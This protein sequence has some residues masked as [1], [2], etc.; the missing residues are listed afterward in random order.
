MALQAFGWSSVRPRWTNQMM[1][2]VSPGLWRVPLAPLDSMNAYLLDDVLVDSG[3]R[4]SAGRLLGALAGRAVRAH[5]VTHA[6]FDH[7]GASH[8]VC[9]RFGVPLWCGAG[10]RAAI[11]SGDL[12]QIL[13]RPRS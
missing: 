5:A 12:S 4:F 9:E 13:P 11:E 1:E 6:H 8:A 10:D 7:V 2:E 3:V